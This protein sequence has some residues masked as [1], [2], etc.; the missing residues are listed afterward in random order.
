MELVEEFF[1]KRIDDGMEDEQLFAFC[2]DIIENIN[3]IHSNPYDLQIEGLQS[4][5]VEYTDK[6][7]RC[8]EMPID[9]STKILAKPLMQDLPED[10]FQENR[11]LV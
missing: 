9:M 10:G 4:L 7:M 5:M 8:L 2:D 1:D 3:L 6:V 11:F